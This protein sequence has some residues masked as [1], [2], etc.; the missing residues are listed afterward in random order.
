MTENDDRLLTLF[1]AEERQREIADDGFS[2]RVMRR[3]PLRHNRLA[4]LWS[5]FCFLT[6]AVLFVTLEAWKPLWNVFREVFTVQLPQAMAQVD[7]SSLVI[8]GLVLLYLFYRKV[9]SLA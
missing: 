3:L 6:A 5:A 9:A 8:A 4:T 1:F 7:T 2:R